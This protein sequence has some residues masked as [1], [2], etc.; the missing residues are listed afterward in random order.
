MSTSHPLEGIIGHSFDDPGLLMTALTHRSVAGG[1]NNERL[2]FLGDALLGSIIA[3]LLYRRFPTA[4]E[5]QLTRMRAAL[6]RRETLAGLARQLGLG[7][8]LR[9]GEG[10]MKSGG[11]RRDSILA[12]TLEA[13]IGA[14]YLDAGREFLCQ[15]LDRLYR[16]RLES[17]TPEAIAKDPKTELQ[18]YLQARQL[19]LPEYETVATGGPPHARRFTV[20]C[21]VC[22]QEPVQATGR[23]RRKAEQAAAAAMLER[24]RAGAS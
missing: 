2:E 1:R 24:L 12:D 11:W 9:L 6:V 22:G 16:P 20:S 17:L 14:I 7:E 15:W 19:P 4:D 23:S 13:L 8:H 18:E 10:E 5:G 21:R 3:E